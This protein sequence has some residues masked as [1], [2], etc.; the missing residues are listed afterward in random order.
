MKKITIILALVLMP[1][2]T[3]SLYAFFTGFGSAGAVKQTVDEAVKQGKISEAGLE[4][5]QASEENPPVEPGKPAVANG[6]GFCAISWNPVTGADSYK[7]FYSTFSGLAKAN[8]RSIS[9]VTSPYMLAG[10]TNGVTYYFG[11][12]AVNTSGDSALSPVST[13]VPTA[14]AAPAPP[15]GVAFT[16]GDGQALIRWSNSTGAT[17]YNLYW[18]NSPIST[19]TTATKIT[20]VTST[21][22]LT[23]LSNSSL[24]YTAVT[25]VNTYGES[26]LSAD[27]S[28]TPVGAI[29]G[30]TWYRAYN[31]GWG[32]TINGSGGLAA[33]CKNIVVYNNKVYLIAGSD[34][35]TSANNYATMGQSCVWSSSSC[36]SWSME[37][38]TAAFGGRY[39]NASVVFNSKIWTTGGRTLGS[40]PTS[41]KNDVYS[42][43]NG[44][45]WMLVKAD[46][47]N[48]YQKR[49]HHG[50]V[51]FNNYIY[52]LGG[53]GTDSC[54]RNDVW[55]SSDGV[56]WTQIRS[57]STPGGFNPRAGFGCVVY[58]SGSG[59]KIWVIAGSSG[60]TLNYNDVWNSSDGVTWAQVVSNPSFSKRS[61]PGVVVHNSK[62]WLI[63]GATNDYYTFYNDAWNSTDG[64]TWTRVTSGADFSERA[65][66]GCI[67]FNNKIWILGGEDYNYTDLD[68]K[69]KDT[70]YT[71]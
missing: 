21:Y 37:T 10:L 64:I 5:S 54:A 26:A 41:R 18:S 50:A 58:N 9:G 42:S 1:L 60:S 30:E 7:L 43:V 44:S 33:L 40:D 51:V 24:Y 28:G 22:T 45:S 35:G 38:S 56:T 20:N 48:G 68:S 53:I 62:L 57:S 63:G 32:P 49:S 31:G 67:S 47:S 3:I 52:V 12:V 23:G 15:T 66:H 39:A 69:L 59:E 34:G 11:V 17:S 61:Q 27:V 2:A 29:V 71:P 55:R 19:T 6:Y 4:P 36:F 70:W 65:G 16:A 13:G 14:M 8:G 46:D 25:A